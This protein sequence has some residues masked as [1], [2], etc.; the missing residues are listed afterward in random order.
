MKAQP[1]LAAIT[2][3][4]LSV[5]LAT[6]AC[7]GDESKPLADLPQGWETAQPIADLQQ[8]E[9]EGSPYDGTAE[10]MTASTDGRAIHIA[11]EPAHFRCA[12]SVQGFAKTA[13]GSVEVLVQPI[14]MNP[15][16]VAHCDCLYGVHMNL[17]VSKGTYAVEV[18]RRWDHKSGADDP[19]KIGSQTVM[20]P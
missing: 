14:D 13:A 6:T 11:Y 4:S 20:I 3:V 2:L 19:L 1:H 12:Q 10:A 7:G 17:P 9:C 5:A 15:A 18:Y 8:T 16:S